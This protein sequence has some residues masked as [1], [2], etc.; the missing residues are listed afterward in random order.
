M[1]THHLTIVKLPTTTHHFTIDKSRLYR[2]PT[3]SFLFL[4]SSRQ[5]LT[6]KRMLSKSKNHYQ[7]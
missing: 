4:Q 7:L 3:L 2:R 6:Q 5:L 1:K